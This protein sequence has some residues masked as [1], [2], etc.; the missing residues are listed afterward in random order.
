MKVSKKD[1]SEQVDKKDKKDN[2]K[3]TDKKEKSVPTV[4]E[5]E[6]KVESIGEIAR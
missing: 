1:N 4:L 6:T 5:V 2:S 3:P